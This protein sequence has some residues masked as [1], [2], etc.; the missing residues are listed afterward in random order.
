MDK[1][2]ITCFFYGVVSFKIEI[3]KH[4]FLKMFKG[5]Y[6]ERVAYPKTEEIKATLKAEKEREEE[7]EK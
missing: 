2:G 3:I 4:S 7:T 5:M 6:H 1:T